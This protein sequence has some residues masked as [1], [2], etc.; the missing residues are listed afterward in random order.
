MIHGLHGG[1]AHLL[2]FPAARRGLF[3]RRLA[4]MLPEARIHIVFNLGGVLQNVVDDSFLKRPPE[5]VQLAHSGLLNCRLPADLER[6]A[7]ATAEG[8]KETLAVGLELALVLE[9]D[10]ELLVIQDVADVE[11]FGVIRNEPLYDA[12]THGC[13]AG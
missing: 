3:G 4:V 9:V 1:G 6:D 2:A 7:F 13:G 5:E 12:E 11:L 8:I 10:D